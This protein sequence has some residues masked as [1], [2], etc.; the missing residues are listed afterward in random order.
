VLNINNEE[1][2]IREI[3]FYYH[4]NKH[5]DTFTHC[6]KEQINSGLW[7][8]HK[9]NGKSYKGG[10]FKGLDISCGNDESSYGGILI[11]SISK[12]DEFIE[13]PCKVVDKIL[14]ICNVSSIS[15]LVP[16]LKEVFEISP[17][18]LSQK[19]T[20]R[21]KEEQRIYT[22]PR[23]GLSLKKNKNLLYIMKPYRFT[24][25]LSIKKYKCLI[26]LQNDI[27]DK[28]RKKWTQYSEEGKTK[29]AEYFT[30]ENPSLKSVKVLCE[31]YGFCKL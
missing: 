19:K 24:N 18:Y 8:F 28:N 22:S 14:E 23:V 17:L 5:P 20:E 4:S 27:Q 29:S 10:S 21:K 11:R 3:E 26:V 6:D 15:E 13:G 31:L 30:T 1:W 12:D 7:Y 2:K 16:K 25:S 9:Q